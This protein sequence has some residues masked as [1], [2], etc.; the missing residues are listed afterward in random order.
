M[1]GVFTRNTV[2][3][4]ASFD[5]FISWYRRSDDGS[6][7]SGN[8]DGSRDRAYFMGDVAI[9]R[10]TN[11]GNSRYCFLSVQTLSHPALWFDFSIHSF[12][13]SSF[14]CRSACRSYRLVSNCFDVIFISDRYYVKYCL[15]PMAESWQSRSPFKW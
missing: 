13:S 5:A 12:K 7:S 10:L 14:G 1:D 4:P 6:S 2:S 11:G 8:G 9:F 3:Y 15:L